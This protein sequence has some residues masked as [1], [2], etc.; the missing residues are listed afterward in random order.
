MN[1]SF[2]LFVLTISILIISISCESPQ[3]TINKGEI[4]EFK[5]PIKLPYL[6]NEISIENTSENVDIF[7]MIMFKDILYFSIGTEFF[8]TRLWCTNAKDSCNIVPWADNLPSA[9]YR[10]ENFIIHND[11]LYYN[12]NTAAWKYSGGT[13]PEEILPIRSFFLNIEYNNELY[14]SSVDDEYDIELYKWNFKNKEDTLAA[15]INPD[16]SS[17]PR[18]FII[19]HGKLYFVASDG[20]NGTELWSYDNTDGAKLVK[21]LI[22]GDR[23]AWPENMFIYNDELYFQIGSGDLAGKTYKLNSATD[24]ITSVDNINEQELRIEKEPCIYDGLLYF[25][26]DMDSTSNEDRKLF[27]YDGKNPAYNNS[28]FDDKE[29]TNFKNLFVYKNQL[30]FYA[31]NPNYGDVYKLWKY[32]PVKGIQLITNKDDNLYRNIDTNSS[33]IICNDILCFIASTPVTGN[34][35]WGYYEE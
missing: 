6:L 23:G 20:K 35:L 15:N 5:P 9:A 28:I 21:D 19:Y 12:T 8:N 30:F 34:A 22:P 25:T 7:D 3:D 14:F 4:A 31:Q 24:E 32:S 10:A 2:I 18:D 26:V 33:M 1:K 11:L 29:L 13:K 16:G 17:F 27:T